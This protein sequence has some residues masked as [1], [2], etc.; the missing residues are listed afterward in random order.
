MVNELVEFPGV[1]NEWEEVDGVGLTVLAA[2]PR[3]SGK[4]AGQA[5]ADAAILRPASGRMLPASQFWSNRES[6]EVDEALL[7]ES[8]G[9]FDER[10][11][12]TPNRTRAPRV[13]TS[14]AMD[15]CIRLGGTE[16]ALRSKETGE[17]WRASLEDLTASGFLTLHQLYIAFGRAPL[18]LTF[19]EGKESGK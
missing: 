16:R 15:A 9:L 5:F 8:G 6:L 4:D 14:A 19:T 1:G 7:Q 17:Y 18:I 12:P 2:L 11:K 3:N 10:P 13:T